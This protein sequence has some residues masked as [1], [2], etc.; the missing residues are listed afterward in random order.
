MHNATHCNSLHHSSRHDSRAI[1]ALCVTHCKPLKHIA[2]HCNT[3]L[4]RSCGALHLLRTHCDTLQH[5]A[6]R[7]N[8]LQHA[9]TYDSRAVAALCISSVHT[10]THCSTRQHAA[11][12]CNTL[13][14]AATHDSRAV[15]ALCIS[16]IEDARE[17]S[18]SDEYVRAC[19][20]DATCA[21]AAVAA[22]AVFENS[23]KSAPSE[24]L[25]SD[26]NGL[27]LCRT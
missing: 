26:C 16:S 19:V 7:C 5:S 27:D 9:A 12:R 15:A 14:H 6:T 11:T 1:A 10:A 23:E 18:C 22:A 20:H 8:T 13:Q 17:T 21:S 2:K 3:R 25:P 24:F 4:T